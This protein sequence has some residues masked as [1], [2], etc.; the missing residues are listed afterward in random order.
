V[1]WQLK[2]RFLAFALIVP[3]RMNLHVEVD[4]VVDEVW[5]EEAE[6]FAGTVVAAVGGAVDFELALAGE[7]LGV[8]ARGDEDGEFQRLRDTAEGEGAAQEIVRRAVGAGGDF[9]GTFNP[10][11]LHLNAHA[12]RTRA[13]SQQARPRNRVSP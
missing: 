2:P 13:P 6:E 5:A 1:T 3:L 12:R 7:A 4:V 10:A 9:L 8:G 11:T